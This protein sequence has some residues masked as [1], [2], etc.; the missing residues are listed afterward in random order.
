MNEYSARLSQHLRDDEQDG[1]RF[2]SPI[3]VAMI[4]EALRSLG[5]YG[6]LHL[7]VEKGRLRFLVTHKSIDTL[8]WR[9][10]ML[11]GESE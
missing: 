3:Q 4:D 8:K 2:L 7:I 11:S 5:D 6:E 1:E 10:G 9:P